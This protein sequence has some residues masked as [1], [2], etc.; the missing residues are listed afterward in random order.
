[1][2]NDRKWQLAW[3]KFDAFKENLPSWIGESDVAEFHSILDLLQESSGEDTS[4]FRIPVDAINPR[5]TSKR[6]GGRRHPSRT[7]YSNKKYCDDDVMRRKIAEVENY[8]RNIQPPPREP[9]YGF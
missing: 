2:N 3:A 6:F 8:F 4:P 7:T 1:M 5:I 9:K